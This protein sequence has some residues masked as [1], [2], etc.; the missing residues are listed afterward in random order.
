MCLSDELPLMAIS[1]YIKGALGTHVN[2][3]FLPLPSPHPSTLNHA[4][5]WETSCEG[6]NPTVAFGDGAS[7]GQATQQQEGMAFSGPL[8]CA[9]LHSPFILPFFTWDYPKFG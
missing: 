2:S 7:S 8:P 6:L 1:T 3:F 9:Q 4:C 5:S